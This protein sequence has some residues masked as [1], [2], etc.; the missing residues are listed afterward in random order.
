MLLLDTEPYAVSLP[1]E[2]HE[3]VTQVSANTLRAWQLEVAQST[4]DALD[5]LVTLAEVAQPIESLAQSVH[6]GNGQ[7]RNL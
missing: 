2:A 5:R 4:S 7:T 3:E 6:S 1:T